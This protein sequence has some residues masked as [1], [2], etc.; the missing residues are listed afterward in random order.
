MNR[1][2]V[3]L[4]SQGSRELRIRMSYLKGAVAVGG[5][6]L[7]G[8]ALLSRDHSNRLDLS[9]YYYQDLPV[10]VL[11][12]SSYYNWNDTQK[13]KFKLESPTSGMVN[14]RAVNGEILFQTYLEASI[15]AEIE[16]A[17]PNEID[18]VQVEYRHRTVNVLVGEQKI[19]LWY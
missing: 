10:D 15:A 14:L 19:A 18:M 16:I 9:S 13:V 8:L 2:L 7:G 6:F 5:V 12:A 1:R 11:M 4:T 3:R 17:I